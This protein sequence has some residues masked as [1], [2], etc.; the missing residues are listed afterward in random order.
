MIWH[1]IYFRNQ[2]LELVELVRLEHDRQIK[3]WGHQRALPQD[4][5]L[6]IAEE[7]GEL[8]QAVADHI[9]RDG[10]KDRIRA[11]AIQVATLALKIALMSED[12]E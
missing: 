2:L 7:E 9:Y 12:P 4:W 6:F 11:E 10:G 1:D 8:A 5:L 3:K